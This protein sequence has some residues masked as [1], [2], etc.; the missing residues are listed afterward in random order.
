MNISELIAELEKHKEKFGDLPVMVYADKLDW[1]EI[2]QV[3]SVYLYPDDSVA[4]DAHY[5]VVFHE[6]AIILSP[7]K[8]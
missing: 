4:D 5:D 8:Y 3:R 2:S 1:G 7:M 6:G